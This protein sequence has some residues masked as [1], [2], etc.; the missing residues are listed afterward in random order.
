MSNTAVF[1][2]RRGGTTRCLQSPEPCRTK[3][4]LVNAANDIVIAKI[5]T[6]MPVREASWGR[7]LALT[8]TLMVFPPG[9]KGGA[10]SGVG[11]KVVVDMITRFF[12]LGA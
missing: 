12:S 5:P 7:D 6:Q 1:T 10:C 9:G 2:Y 8:E 11:G 3:S 4:A